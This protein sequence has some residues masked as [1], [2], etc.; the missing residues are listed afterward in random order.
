M[1]KKIL[2]LI[3]KGPHFDL[4]VINKKLFVFLVFFL[5]ITPIIFAQNQYFNNNP[6]WKISSGCSVSSCFGPTCIEYR[7]Y[8]YY[9]NGDTIF[10]SRVYKRLFMKGTANLMWYS[11]PTPPCCDGSYV[12]NDTIN[13]VAFLRDT[14]NKIYVSFG[15][16]DTLLFDYNLSVG[17]SLPVTY[18][19]YESNITVLSIDSIPVG[20]QY[21]KRFQLSFTGAQYLIEGIGHDKGLL[22]TIN[23]PLECGWSLLCYGLA[24][25]AYYPQI[26]TTCNINVGV[27]DEEVLSNFINIFPNPS[28]ELFTISFP[29]NFINGELE[30]YSVLGEKVYSDNINKQSKKEIN[31]KKIGAGIYFVKVFD[32]EKSYSKKLIIE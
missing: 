27:K 28:S 32:G 1:K 14:L 20:N 3:S 16:Q 29:D 7:T 22:E 21:R 30:I 2:G 23:I 4:N 25:T 9:I 10:N 8:N 19:N 18:N 26:G 17:D 5:F 12:F 11:F 13:P 31:L 24:D 15:N 6:V